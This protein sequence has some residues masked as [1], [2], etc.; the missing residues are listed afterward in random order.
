MTSRSLEPTSSY[1]AQIVISVKEALDATTEL[2]NV[3]FRL[4]FARDV[5]FVVD[6]L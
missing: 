2:T 4:D 5:R 3:I 1:A 6:D